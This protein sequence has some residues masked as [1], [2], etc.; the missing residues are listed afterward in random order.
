MRLSKPAFWITKDA[1]IYDTSSGF[2]WRHKTKWRLLNPARALPLN[3]NAD[4]SSKTYNFF[5][6]STVSNLR[7]YRLLVSSI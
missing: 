5:R 2:G 3:F 4:T 6:Y 7:D 1:V